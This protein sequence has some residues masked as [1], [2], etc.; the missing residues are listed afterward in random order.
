MVDSHL[1]HAEHCISPAGHPKPLRLHE[2]DGD[3]EQSRQPDDDKRDI[4]EQHGRLLVERC[5]EIGEKR[6]IVVFWLPTPKWTLDTFFLFT[7]NLG[8]KLP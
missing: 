2:R 7:R 8:R 1:R 4:S 5:W 6:L 3:R